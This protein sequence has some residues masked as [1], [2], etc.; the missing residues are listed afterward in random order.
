MSWLG[1][2]WDKEPRE[3]DWDKEIVGTGNGDW[4]GKVTR[5]KELGGNN[6]E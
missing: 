6:Q 5:D 2:V 1:S 3:E 4:L